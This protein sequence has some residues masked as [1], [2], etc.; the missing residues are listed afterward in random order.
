MKQTDKNEYKSSHDW[1]RKILKRELTDK[2]YM[3]KA[4]SVQEN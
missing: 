4:E 3:L 1:V 2:W